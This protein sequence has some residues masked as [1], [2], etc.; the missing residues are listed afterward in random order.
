MSRTDKVTST[1]RADIIEKALLAADHV[2]TKSA[3]TTEEIASTPH[4][5]TPAPTGLAGI[6][7]ERGN[8]YGS[9]EANASLSQEIKDAIRRAD[10]EN[11]NRLSPVQLEAIE[12][13]LHK[14]S[15]I[16]NGDPRYLD[17]WVD[18]E[19]YL[20]LGRQWTEENGGH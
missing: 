5:A 19:S 16:V 1:I 8:R 13:A 2:V 7:S 6:Q 20:N 12:M 4:V 3:V 15:R 14:I 17:S 18:A 11:S 10:D 9:F